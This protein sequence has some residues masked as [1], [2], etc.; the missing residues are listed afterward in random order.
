MSLILRREGAAPQVSGLFFKSVIQ[1][2]LLFGVETWVVTP[3]MGKALGGGLDRGGD[4]AD[5]MAPVDHTGREVE[6][7]LGGGGGKGGGR[8]IDNGGVYQ[9]SSEHIHTVHCYT[10][11]VRPVWGFLKVHGGASRYA[12]VGKGKN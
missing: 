1:A 9:R 12:V 10:I 8:I 7:H 3:R 4:T 2:V 11:T 5:G 6:I